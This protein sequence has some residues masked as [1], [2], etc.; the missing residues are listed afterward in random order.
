MAE[1]VAQAFRGLCF[2]QFETKFTTKKQKLAKMA[3]FYDFG[4]HL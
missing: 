4:R 2:P 1:G 3:P